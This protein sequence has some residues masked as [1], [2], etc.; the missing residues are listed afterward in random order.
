[1]AMKNSVLLGAGVWCA[2]LA[3]VHFDHYWVYQ[4]SRWGVCAAAVFGAVTLAGKPWQW[5]LWALAVLFNPIAP[6]HFGRDVWQIL[7]G[8][9]A[10]VFIIA[11]FLKK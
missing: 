3:L 9:A 4:L 5:P 11:T 7:D 10:L 1:M 2:V 8:V 6:I